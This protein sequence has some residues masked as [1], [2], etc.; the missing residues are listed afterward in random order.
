MARDG[1]ALLP[2]DTVYGLACDPESPRAV[3]RLYEIKGRPPQQPSAVMYFSLEAALAA[4]PELAEGERA[5]L[6]ALLPGA[7]TVL[8]PNPRSRFPLACA[9]E[10][11]MQGAGGGAAPVGSAGERPALGLRV[12]ELSPSIAA[13]AAMRRPVM[14]SSANLSGG[15]EARLFEE[16]PASVREA[17]DL[18][19]DGGELPGLASTILDLRDYARGGTWRVLRE[20]PLGA[21]EIE[22]RLLAAG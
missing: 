2:T 15:P 5:A 16:V 10:T 19:L 11:A 9:P 4:L 17:V 14:Q 1:V 21:G 20:G 22:R 12:P 3:E 13:L 18:G 7:L 6:R 8:L